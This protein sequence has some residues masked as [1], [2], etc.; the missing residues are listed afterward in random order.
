MAITRRFMR[1]VTPTQV[2]DVLRDG[3]S[4]GHWVVGTRKIRDV[5]SGWPAEG[6]KLHYTVGYRPLRKDDV[7]TS[8]SYEA[9][10][11]LEL[12]ARAWPA[13]TALIVLT[14]KAV[15]DGTLVSIDEQPWRGIARTL[16]NPLADA[17]IKVRNVE[18]LRRL[19]Q[20]A[21]SR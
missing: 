6:T 3:F 4:Y 18:T 21:R 20:Q 17:V 2:F 9:D 5:D 11:R 19:E 16:H 1:G 15:D 13:G 12:E 8:R 7:T 14:A 10:S